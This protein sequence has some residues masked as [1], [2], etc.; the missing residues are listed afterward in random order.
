MRFELFI[1]RTQVIITELVVIIAIF[2]PPHGLLLILNERNQIIIGKLVDNSLLLRRDVNQ[3]FAEEALGSVGGH[4]GPVLM[5]GEGEAVHAEGVTAVE[6]EEGRVW[7]EA[8]A[9]GLAL[10]RLVRLGFHY[11]L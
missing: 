1:S 3:L 8:F 5:V 6:M 10:G 2:G 9:A 7:L 11:R 4:E